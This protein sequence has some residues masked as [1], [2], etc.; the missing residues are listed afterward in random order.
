MHAETLRERDR[1]NYRLQDI[2]L[3]FDAAVEPAL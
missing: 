3:P 2:Q 1:S